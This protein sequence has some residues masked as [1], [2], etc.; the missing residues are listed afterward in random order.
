MEL[1][2]VSTNV[3]T[4]SNISTSTNLLTMST[5]WIQLEAHL[6]WHT[7]SYVWEVMVKANGSTTAYSLDGIPTVTFNNPP[8]CLQ[9]NT[10]YYLKSTTSSFTS[11]KIYS[12]HTT[13]ANAD[14]DIKID[15]VAGEMGT[16]STFSL[17]FIRK[18]YNQNVP[19]GGS[20]KLNRFIAEPLGEMACCY[21]DTFSNMTEASFYF[22]P[23][24]ETVV[25]KRSSITGFGTTFYLRP[26][27]IP[28]NGTSGIYSFSVGAGGIIVN[29]K[30]WFGYW[31]DMT[32]TIPATVT[33]TYECSYVSPAPHADF[34]SGTITFQTPM[35]IPD[36]RL[37]MPDAYLFVA[38]GHHISVGTIDTTLTYDTGTGCWVSEVLNHYNIPGRIYFS[39]NIVPRDFGNAGDWNFVMK[40]EHIYPYALTWNDYA[41]VD[42]IDMRVDF[43]GQKTGAKSLYDTNPIVVNGTFFTA[44]LPNP[45]VHMAESSRTTTLGGYNG[46]EVFY[47]MKVMES[48]GLTTDWA[49]TNQIAALPNGTPLVFVYGPMAISYSYYQRAIK[50]RFTAFT[51]GDSGPF[52][53]PPFK[54]LFKDDLR[55]STF[56]QGADRFV[57]RSDSND[58]YMTSLPALP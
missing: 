35:T 38:T 20:V 53:Y 1:A 50:S 22:A 52:T 49:L 51:T 13:V 6:A 24:G 57:I 2:S 30:E 19:H 55:T 18:N 11:P 8:D 16:G 32:H 48:D 34:G 28:Y 56:W 43:Y 21:P 4:K 42:S 25:C 7:A 23:T 14:A 26:F 44:Y 41:Y 37:Y 45:R 15:F 10:V 54:G 47:K 5:S 27:G 36:V 31:A 3:I 46:T 33:G 12:F 29:W 17:I 39:A 40:N 9:Q 58:C